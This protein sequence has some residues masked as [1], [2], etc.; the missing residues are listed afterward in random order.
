M[1]EKK[2]CLTQH[3]NQTSNRTLPFHDLYMHVKLVEWLLFS[4]V[5]KVELKYVCT[6]VYKNT[7]EINNVCVSYSKKIGV[8]PKLFYNVYYILNLWPSEL[9]SADRMHG[10]GVRKFLSYVYSQQNILKRKKQQ[11]QTR[12]H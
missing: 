6:H 5:S 9:S 1:I 10:P 3:L 7:Y 12:T 2:M 4:W 8:A 11:K